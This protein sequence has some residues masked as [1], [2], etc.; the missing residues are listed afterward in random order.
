MIQ[1]HCWDT[2]G[3]ES[4]FMAGL[5]ARRRG[6]LRRIVTDDGRT[7]ENNMAEVRYSNDKPN[8]RGLSDLGDDI[9][10]KIGLR[11][12][13]RCKR[14]GKPPKASRTMEPSRSRTHADPPGNKPYSAAAKEAN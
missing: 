9:T 1:A 5:Y 2:D 6:E 3:I 11:L 4:G 7:G 10:A 13:N 8:T 14:L 12:N